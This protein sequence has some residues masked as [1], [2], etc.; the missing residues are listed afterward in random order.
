MHKQTHTQPVCV[1]VEITMVCLSL[2]GSAVT[3]TQRRLWWLDGT[4]NIF[5]R[6]LCEVGWFY[7]FY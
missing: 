1:L 7:C 6:A 2:N 5:Y 3:M 4:V